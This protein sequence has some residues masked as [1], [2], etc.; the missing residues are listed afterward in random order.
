MYANE[1]I[2]IPF[3]SSKC[4]TTHSY[5]PIPIEYTVPHNRY[6]SK[7]SQSD[8]NRLAYDDILEN[9]QKFADENG[10]CESNVV[11]QVYNP[12]QIRFSVRFTWGVPGNYQYGNLPV[13][14]GER[15]ATTGDVRKDFKPSE[16]RVPR[17]DYKSV[18]IFDYDNNQFDFTAGSGYD[19]VFPYLENN[20]C[21]DIYII[22]SL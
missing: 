12:T 3:R 8:A 16:I 10:K 19:S 14:P 21:M 7:I 17:L 9:G 1:T 11:I 22:N 4:D 20:D 2:S 15:I 5:L 6:H 18:A 13:E